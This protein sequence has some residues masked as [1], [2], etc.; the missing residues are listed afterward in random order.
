MIKDSI[1]GNIKALLVTYNFEDENALKAFRKGLDV[2]L[3]EST[4]ERVIIIVSIP[5]SIDKNSLSP[6]F[7]IYYNGPVTIHFL[8]D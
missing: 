5:K 8:E 1:W 2:V 7:L 3:N 4:V 6:H